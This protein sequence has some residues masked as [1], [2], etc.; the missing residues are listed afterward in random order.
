MAI[1]E[2]SATQTIS[3]EMNSIGCDPFNISQN[4]EESSSSSHILCF[5][6]KQ[7]LTKEEKEAF[8]NC[9]TTK[10]IRPNALSIDEQ[11]EEGPST[12]KKQRL[13]KAKEAENDD[14]PGFSD[15]S[16]DA[17]PTLEKQEQVGF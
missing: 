5:K 14:S 15:I 10:I 12:T 8:K 4:N 2:S 9:Q 17:A 13:Q 3:P 7:L 11:E 6:C 1:L 16:D